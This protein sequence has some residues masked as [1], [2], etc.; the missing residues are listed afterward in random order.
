MN[1]VQ[2]HRTDNGTIDLFSVMLS[3]DSS[4]VLDDSLD[5]QDILHL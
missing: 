2:L 1:I 5:N 4:I 3:Y